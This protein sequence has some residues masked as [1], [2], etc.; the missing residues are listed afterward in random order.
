MFHRWAEPLADGVART[1]AEEIA[2][3][4]PT[5]RV[6]AY[7]WRGLFGR[8]IQ[9]QVVIV[10]V[11]FDGRPGGDITLDTRWRILGKNGDELAFK[12]STVTESA[13]G[14]GYEPMVAAMNRALLALGREIASEIPPT[15][16]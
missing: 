12:R 9:F 13:A 6:I 14:S 10:V 15:R 5:D 4:V 3:R 7:P 11:R 1:V 2:L 8:A 16:P